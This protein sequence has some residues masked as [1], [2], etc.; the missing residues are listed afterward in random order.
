MLYH[1]KCIVKVNTFCNMV[2]VICTNI[3]YIQYVMW[4]YVI[5]TITANTNVMW[6][7]V[8]YTTTVKTGRNV[9]YVICIHA[10]VIASIAMT[11]CH[12]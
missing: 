2:H 8:I 7:R 1:V 4:Y 11:A 10:V 5:C 3:Q 9:V 6:Y 12:S